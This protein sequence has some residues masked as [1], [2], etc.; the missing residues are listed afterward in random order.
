MGDEP[1]GNNIEERQT[2]ADAVAGFEPSI[3]APK[4]FKY[5]SA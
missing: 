3:G 2:Q 5:Y 4:R 1:M